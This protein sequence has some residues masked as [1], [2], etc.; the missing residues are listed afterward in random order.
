MADQAKKN[1]FSGMQVFGIV[2]LVMVL[3]VVGTIFAARAWLFPSSFTPVVLSQ[4]EEKQLENKL[5]RF[6]MIGSPTAT[7]RLQ[8]DQQSTNAQENPA[9]R[10]P[11]GSLK[12]EAYSEEGASREITLS[13]REINA[14]LAKNTDLADKLAVDFAA[15]LVSAKMLIPV[16]PDFPMFG[17]KILRVKAGV[18]LAYRGSRPVVKI[19]GVSI[20]GVPVPAAWMGGLKNIDLIEQFGTDKG[21]WKEFS[22]GVDSITVQ[23]GRLHI[24]LKE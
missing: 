23:D 4:Q 7:S 11:D 21:F 19:R 16:D 10:L 15:N 12:P 13:E 9:K 14:I 3:T 17:G 1:G 20:M 6:E 2:V 18:E 8:N 5:Q 24:Q 22:D